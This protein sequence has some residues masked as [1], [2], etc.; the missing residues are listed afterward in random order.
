MPE[1]AFSLVQRPSRTTFGL[2]ATLLAAIGA[3]INNGQ[4]VRIGTSGWSASRKKTIYRSLHQFGKTTPY[5]LVR[6]RTPDEIFVW[7]AKK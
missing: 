1:L 7:G 6:R 3:T 2:P 4:A 5:V